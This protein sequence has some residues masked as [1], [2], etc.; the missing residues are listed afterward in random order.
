MAMDLTLQSTIITVHDPDLA[1]AF[2]RDTLGLAVTADVA[3]GDSRWVTVTSPSD[4]EVGLVLTQP[5]AGRSAED[6]DALEVLMTK[7]ALHQI[8]FRSNDVDGDFEKVQA[9]GAEV[10]QEPMDQG[11]G[12][13]DCAFRDPS[14]NTVRLSQKVG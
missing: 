2:Y 7:G 13:R 14:G 5:H 3:F 4:P 10:L 1:I 11:W 8:V 6:G 9:S 12:A